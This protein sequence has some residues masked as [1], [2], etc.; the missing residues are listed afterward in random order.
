MNRHSESELSAPFQSSGSDY[1][2]SNSESELSAPFQSSGSDYKPSNE[3]RPSSSNS[4]AQV[5]VETVA[6]EDN[7]ETCVKRERKRRKMAKWAR[8]VQTLKKGHRNRKDL[9]PSLNPPPVNVSCPEG[10]VGV[11]PNQITEATQAQDKDNNADIHKQTPK[12]ITEATQAQDKDNNADIHKQTPKR[13]V[14]LQS[15]F[16]DYPF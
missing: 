4:D 7:G 15:W 9:K 2:P 11:T 1:K 10:N 8:N 16:K 6:V 13:T 12:Q 3:D 5:M 14:K